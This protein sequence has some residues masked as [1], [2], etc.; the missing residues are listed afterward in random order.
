MF[1]VTHVFDATVTDALVSVA[2]AAMSSDSVAPDK[3]S[4]PLLSIECKGVC[5]EPAFHPLPEPQRSRNR[6]RGLQGVDDS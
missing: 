1:A 5:S 6:T 3:G 4:E 2:G